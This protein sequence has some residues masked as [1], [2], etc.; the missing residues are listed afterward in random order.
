MLG[1][2]FSIIV[3]A[4]IS[5]IIARWQIK[6]NRIVHFYSNSYDI[7]K[8]LSNE[9]PDFQLHYG[10]EKLVDDVKVL[11]GGFM[12]IGRKDIDGL[13]GEY[14]IKLILPEGCKIKAFTISPSTEDLVVTANNDKEN[15]NILCFGVNDVLK[16]DEYFKYS[17]IVEA[18]KD[19]KYLYDKLKFHHRI[20]NTEK[21]RNVYLGQQRPLFSKK[22]I[23]GLIS[24]MVLLSII[25]IY[26]Y[27]YQK[28]QY[29]VCQKSNDKEVKIYLDPFSNIHVDEGMTIP[30]ISGTRISSDKLKKDYKIVPVMEFKWDHPEIISLIIG[31]AAML[32]YVIFIY[33]LFY[34]K[35][36]HIIKVIRE[37]EENKKQ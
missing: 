26:V 22:I 4:V 21:I 20:L 9:F 30:Y 24:I 11:K 35:N 29:R 18:P 23:T 19:I 32:F 37:N 25:F 3:T 28:L 6:K 7:G 1:I 36:G 13:K 10:G 5:I 34:G 16:T 15:D 8:G 33:Y 31:V 17:A 14:D 2:I 27:S 12:N